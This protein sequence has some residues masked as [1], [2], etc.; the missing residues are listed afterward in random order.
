VLGLRLKETKGSNIYHVHLE[1]AARATDS[2]D[3]TIITIPA[4]V[5]ELVEKRIK[6]KKDKNF[7]LAD[8]I[9]NKVKEMG[10]EL[11]DKKDGVEVKKR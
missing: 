10:Y 3:V 4:E 11:I 8:E 6:A 9:R 5:K 7:K 2:I 1:E